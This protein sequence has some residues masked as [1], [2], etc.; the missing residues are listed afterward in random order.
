MIVPPDSSFQRHTRRR[1]SSRPTSSFVLP[2]AASWRSTTTCV[3]MPAWS[4]PGTQRVLKRSMRFMRTMTSCRVMSSA[5][6]MCS[7]PVTFGGGMTI[8][9]GF[10]F[11]G[12]SGRK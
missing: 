9:N 3:A 11:D 4:V 7:E 2:S 1:N 12:S 10:F 6:P 5:W 8:E